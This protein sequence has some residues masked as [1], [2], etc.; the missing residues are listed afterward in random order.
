MEE[1]EEVFIAREYLQEFKEVFEAVLIAK[2]ELLR[3]DDHFSHAGK[4]RDL[5][6]WEFSVWEESRKKYEQALANAIAMLAGEL[7]ENSK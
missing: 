2:H 4:H 1:L 3:N 6:E 7:K 5:T